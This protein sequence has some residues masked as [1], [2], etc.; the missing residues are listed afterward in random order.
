[1]HRQRSQC[2]QS[3]GGC[4]EQREF[5]ALAIRRVRGGREVDGDERGRDGPRSGRGH[6]AAAVRGSRC[7]SGAPPSIHAARGRGAVVMRLH[8]GLYAGE[9]PKRLSR[10]PH[11]S[12][13]PS[14][15]YYLRSLSRTS[16]TFSFPDSRDLL[17]VLGR[18]SRP[19]ERPQGGS[20]RVRED[21]LGPPPLRSPFFTAIRAT[22]LSWECV[23]SLDWSPDGDLTSVSSNFLGISNPHN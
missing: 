8:A 19:R 1:M 13:L 15:H 9:G 6:A 5:A 7:G 3:G 20:P 16:G 22:A 14:S 21:P 23:L 11:L 4:E 12:S 10:Y 17:E 18:L 2:D